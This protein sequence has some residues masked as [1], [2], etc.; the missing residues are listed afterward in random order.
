IEK[1]DSFN[2]YSE[3]KCH[4]SLM[5]DAIRETF[6]SLG[7]T[8]VMSLE[9]RDGWVFV[10]LKKSILYALCVIHFLNNVETNVYDGWPGVVEVGGCIPRRSRE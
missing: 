2:M 8:E 5:T 9:T 4:W 7:S 10:G 3:S 6:V 1:V